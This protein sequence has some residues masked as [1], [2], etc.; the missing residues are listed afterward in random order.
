[1][2]KK[3]D[4]YMKSLIFYMLV[5]FLPLYSLASNDIQ[6][7]IDSA[8][9]AFSQGNYLGALNMYEKLLDEGNYSEISLYRMAFLN[10][11]MQN[12]PAAIFCLKRISQEYGGKHLQE[13]IVQ[14]MQKNGSASYLTDELWTGYF[15]FWHRWSWLIWTIFISSGLALAAFFFLKMQNQKKYFKIAALVSGPVFAIFS[16]VLFVHLFFAPRR[17][18]IL[19][20]TA[21]YSAPAYSAEFRLYGFSTGETVNII[22]KK[23]IWRQVRAGEKIFWVP[24]FV[25]KE[26]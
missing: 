16:I 4:N 21:Y 19:N 10:E 14:L 15:L 20:P 23:D 18:V 9:T 11:Q 24:E 13:K 3:N 2:T 1:M 25:L 7:K 6:A 26:L 22:N 8:D 5:A 12:F 17:A